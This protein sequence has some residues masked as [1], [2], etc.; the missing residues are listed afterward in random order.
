MAAIPIVRNSSSFRRGQRRLLR[1]ACEWLCALLISPALHA[2]S[3]APAEAS[4]HFERGYQLAQEGKLEAAIDEF[5]QAYALKPHPLVLYNLGQAYA[6]SG[7]ALEA[8]KVLERYLAEASQTDPHREQATAMIDHQS[9]RVGELLLEVAP[10]GAELRV[11]GVSLGLAPLPK[12]IELTA[13]AHGVLVRLNGYEAHAE[14]VSIVGKQRS[15]LSVTLRPLAVP[16]PRPAP[17]VVRRD[18]AAEHAALAL[19]VERAER[20]RTQRVAALASA[21]LGVS[22][23]VAAAILFAENQAAY[24]DWNRR[25]HDFATRLGSANNPTPRELDRL[26]ARENTLRNRDAWALGLGVFGGV[27]SVASATLWFTLPGAEPR[28][29]SIQL[30]PKPWLGY[31]ANF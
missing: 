1:L 8:V 17:A 13:G 15:T 24:D 23:L 2:E 20:A 18:V 16:A 10:A 9:Q 30:G 31:S 25:S 12:P 3:A 29:V 22:S 21:G 19:R 14:A 6:A 4:E 11:D 7:R 5:N 26:L 28:R 27:L